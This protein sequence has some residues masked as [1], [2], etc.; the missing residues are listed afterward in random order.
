[1]AA[2]WKAGK[3]SG[4]HN[5]P[6]F[7]Y[8]ETGSYM[9]LSAH[10]ITSSVLKMGVPMLT[11]CHDLFNDAVTEIWQQTGLHDK[12]NLQRFYDNVKRNN[13]IGNIIPIIGEFCL[14]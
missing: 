8:V 14:P 13:Y 5:E 9:G 12:T 11:Y 1:M 4:A 3:E 10:I 7:K 2:K 6:Y